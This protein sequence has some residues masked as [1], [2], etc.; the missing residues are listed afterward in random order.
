MARAPHIP[1]LEETNVRQGFLEYEDYRKVLGELP[2]HLKA[3]FVVGYH[4]GVRI[5]ELRKIRWAQVDLMARE[6]K[7]E[8]GKTKNKKPR[9]LPI[10]GDMIA[11]LSMQRTEHEAKWP[12]CP[13]VFHRYKKPLGS[14][15]KGWLEAVK[16]A[17]FPGLRFHDLRR[18]AIRNME[19]AG[20]PRH[21]AMAISG[22]RTEAIYRRYDIVSQRDLELA[23]ARDG[24]LPQGL[25]GDRFKHRRARKAQT[26]GRNPM[27]NMGWVEGFE[28]SATGTTIQRSTS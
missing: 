18:S 14:H 11:W 7:L 5:G 2:S 27:K 17:G 6:I 23:G 13:L 3:A 9:T 19:R 16:T 8:T 15:L 4:V 1:G 22:H 12:D 28:P 24:E 21:V 25:K 20:I 26:E 10:Y